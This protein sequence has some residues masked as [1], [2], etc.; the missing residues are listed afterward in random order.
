[1]Q[2]AIL[3]L[4]PLP[5]SSEERGDVA[6][7]DDSISFHLAHSRQRE[8]EI[9]QDRLLSFFEDDPGLHPRDI[10]VMTPD[11]EAYAPHIEA[12]FGNV[13]AVDD[14]FIPFTIGDRP[15]SGSRPLISALSM[16]LHLPDS[17]LTVGEVMDLLE[18]SVVSSGFRV[19]PSAGDFPVSTGGALICPGIW[20][21]TPGILV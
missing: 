5:P 10:I 4:T 21:R 20:N 14:R 16:L 19:P 8:V 9:L 18:I 13:R 1:M 2:Q 6:L 11:I 7:G 17:R 12:V 15:G 3:D